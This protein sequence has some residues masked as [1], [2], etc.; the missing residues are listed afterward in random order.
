MSILSLLIIIWHSKETSLFLTLEH[1]VSPNHNLAEQED[2]SLELQARLLVLEAAAVASSLRAGGVSRF[3]I[4][5]I[6]LLIVDN[7]IDN[8]IQDIIDNIIDTLLIE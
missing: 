8:I 7:I 2:L 4:L 5:L 1:S 6:I 3:I